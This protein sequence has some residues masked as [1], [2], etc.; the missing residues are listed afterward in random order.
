ML[1]RFEAL[2][3]YLTALGDDVQE[4]VLRFYIAFKRIRNFACVE[5]RPMAE[6]ILVYV[7]VDPSSLVLEPGFTRDVSDIGHYGTGDLEITLSK[8]EDLERAKPLIQRSYDDS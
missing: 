7:K 2:R 3:A 4:T 1:D 6:K 5:F 8:S